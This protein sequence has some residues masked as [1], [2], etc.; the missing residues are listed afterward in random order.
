V[1]PAM[2]VR[3][4]C[5]RSRRARMAFAGFL[6]SDSPSTRTFKRPADGRFLCRLRRGDLRRPRFQLRPRRCS[7]RVAPQSAVRVH[8]PVC[9]LVDACSSLVG[10]CGTCRVT[11]RWAEMRAFIL[12]FVIRRQ[13][14]PVPSPRVR[15]HLAFAETPTIIEKMHL[16]PLAREGAHSMRQDA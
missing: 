8:G 13:G 14:H 6:R 5:E 2:A 12:D 15:A 9:E 11:S 7:R 10:R 16:V 3:V 1:A 4:L